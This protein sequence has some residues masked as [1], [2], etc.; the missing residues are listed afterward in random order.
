MAERP[1]VVEVLEDVDERHDGAEDP[2]GRREAAGRRPEVGVVLMAL[3]HPVDLGLEDRPDQVG[4]GAVHHELQALLG[5]LVV[6]L[7]QVVLQ[8]EQALLTGLLG[9]LD[10]LA[11][12]S[13]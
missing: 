8:R 6:D 3:S 5:V 1:R 7:R 2:E 9:E 13:A 12:A 11:E 10:H 4:V